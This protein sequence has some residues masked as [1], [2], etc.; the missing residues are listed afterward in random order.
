[1]KKL[2]TFL[3]IVVMLIACSGGG[4]CEYATNSE[5]QC[6]TTTPDPSSG[7]K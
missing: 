4:V 6:A 5:F 7:N 2:K 3:F 1:M